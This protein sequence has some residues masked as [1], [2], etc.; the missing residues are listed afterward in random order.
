MWKKMLVLILATS[1]ITVSSAF[2]QSSYE[3]RVG[4]QVGL[5]D[6]NGV[7]LPGNNAASNP[8]IDGAVVHFISAGADNVA[9]PPASDGSVTGDDVLL[10]THAIGEGIAF[11]IQVSGKFAFTLTNSNIPSG[12]FYVRVFNKAVLS[13]ATHYGQ[14]TPASFE[15]LPAGDTRWYYVNQY[16]LT[17]T[18]VVLN[19]SQNEPP[20][21][22][23]G[24]PYTI[25]E[26]SAIQLDASA[27]SDPDD[28]TGDLD[29]AWDL[30]C[31]GEFDDASGMNPTTA[32][33]PDNTTAQIAVKVTDPSDNVSYALASVTVNNVDPFADNITD[34]SISEGELV[35]ISVAYSDPG[36]LDTH[37]AS[38]DWGD[39]N[40]VNNFA[41]QNNTINLEHQYTDFN[42]Y[43]AK[44]TVTDKDG[45]FVEKTFQVNVAR[46]P[47]DLIYALEDNRD[48]VLSW[49]TVSGK[50]YEVW[51]TD[52]TFE[53]FGT[54]GMVWHIAAVTSAGEFV[55]QGDADG[56]DNEEGTADDRQHPKDV[57]IRYYRVV[58]AGSID[59]GNPWASENIVFYRNIDLYPGRNFVGKKCDSDKLSETLDGRFLIGSDLMSTSTIVDFWQG[60]AQKSAYLYSEDD[61]M[62]WLNPS[63]APLAD[64]T[65]ATGAGLI[66]T[67][68]ESAVPYVTMPVCGTVI[69]EDSIS[70][71]INAN[72]YTTVSYPFEG[73]IALNQSGL[74][75]SGLKSNTTS[76][77]ADNIYFYNAETQRYD[78]VVFH[79]KS[80]NGAV[81]EWRY[82]NQTPCTRKIKA[83]E[84]FLIKTNSMSALT[85]WVVNR[86][87]PRSAS[88]M[89]K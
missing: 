52:T 58:L 66:V 76:R 39:G 49:N 51:Y 73:E 59:A 33:W 88:N 55:D 16:G 25:D 47:I 41:V 18:N 22:N 86:P 83:G 35:S 11:F 79:Y 21:A 70:I 80:A 2:A 60:T 9:N 54:A 56:Y 40:I 30:D 36:A 15:T 89:N 50:E 62:L 57:D 46:V 19:Q 82:M 29:F 84:A 24:G 65:I 37:T 48:I 38:I 5:T 4:T 7:L 77:T 67:M 72:D 1:G 53:K 61:L 20:V 23:A 45:G 85:N 6:Q 8:H 71:A 64:D 27:T 63:G 32:V 12:F 14:S 75:E 28:Q 26:G 43:T 42:T 74:V 17:S 3:L 31:D 81:Q 10:S 44:L 87:Y 69:M 78:L 13:E 68:P 34:K